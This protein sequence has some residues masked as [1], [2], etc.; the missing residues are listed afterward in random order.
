MIKE[1]RV[2]TMPQ[3]S[4]VAVAC[5]AATCVAVCCGVVSVIKA[6]GIRS[7]GLSVSMKCVSC[8]CGK[9]INNSIGFLRSDYL[10]PSAEMILYF[11]LPVSALNSLHNKEHL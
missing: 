5:C 2:V 3:R 8:F 9:L 4:L 7:M 10:T 6:P 1:H 11:V